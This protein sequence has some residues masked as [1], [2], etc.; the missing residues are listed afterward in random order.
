MEKIDERC[1]KLTL[2]EYLTDWQGKGT[3]AVMVITDKQCVFYTQILPNDF[4]THDDISINIENEIH[5]TDQRYG[6]AAMRDNH[7]YFFFDKISL[8]T[9]K[10]SLLVLLSIAISALVC[11]LKIFFLVNI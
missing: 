6:W 9:S 2:H 10:L 5:P 7:T 3:R 1:L 4:K 11:K 8:L